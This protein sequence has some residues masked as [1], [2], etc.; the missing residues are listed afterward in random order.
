MFTMFMPLLITVSQTIY[1][2]NA[3]YAA[4]H[5]HDMQELAFSTL[6]KKSAEKCPEN[7][8]E[9][10]SEPQYSYFN[11]GAHYVDHAFVYVRCKGKP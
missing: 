7:G 1:G 4:S 3:M 6:E 11:G 9:F 8:A 2:W 5:V 10:V